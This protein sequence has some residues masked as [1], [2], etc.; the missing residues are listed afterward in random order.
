MLVTMF[1]KLMQVLLKANCAKELNVT[2]GAG[3]VVYPSDLRLLING[4]PLSGE[5]YE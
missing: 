4:R 3:I 5:V 1:Y 2:P